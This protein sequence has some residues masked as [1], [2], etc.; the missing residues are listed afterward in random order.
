MNGHTTELIP[1]ESNKTTE[2]LISFPVTMT[3]PFGDTAYAKFVPI[4]TVPGVVVLRRKGPNVAKLLTERTADSIVDA[5][6]M[7]LLTLLASL[8]AGIIVWFLVSAQ[9]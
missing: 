3:R 8:L 1:K 7:F 2:P 4:I 9:I 5:W 6:P